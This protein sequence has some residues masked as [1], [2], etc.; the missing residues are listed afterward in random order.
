MIHPENITLN[1]TNFTIEKVSDIC[2]GNGQYSPDCLNKWFCPQISHYFVTYA[3][4]ITI[5]YVAVSWLLW[6]YWQWINEKL[7]WEE[8][9]HCR[10]FNAVVMQVVGDLRIYEN[11][12]RLEFFIK[13][14]LEKLLLG[15]V[16]I[17]WWFYH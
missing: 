16:I 10:G 15:F 6:A 9:T 11:K 4:I 3:L 2:Y 12:V 1:L 7:P 14:K 17:L 8:I 13:D 5:T